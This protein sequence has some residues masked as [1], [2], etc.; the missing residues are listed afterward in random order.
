MHQ[1]RVS[2]QSQQQHLDNNSEEAAWCASEATK[3]G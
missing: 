1:K 3:K 2:V